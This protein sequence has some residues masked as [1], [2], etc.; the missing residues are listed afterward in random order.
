[1]VDGYDN[2][3]VLETSFSLTGS[4]GSKILVY[5]LV[6]IGAIGVITTGIVV[7]IKIRKTRKMEN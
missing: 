2:L 5:I 1:M 4:S 7:V 3:E 6:P